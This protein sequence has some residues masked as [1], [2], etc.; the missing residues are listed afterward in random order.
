[1][2]LIYKTTTSVEKTIKITKPKYKLNTEYLLEWDREPT[3][4]LVSFKYAFWS[5]KE[6][7]WSYCYFD[8]EKW[9]YYINEQD[10]KLINIK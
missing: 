2:K 8:E 7:L 1:M 3:A 6:H 10:I 4:I 9:N 5:L